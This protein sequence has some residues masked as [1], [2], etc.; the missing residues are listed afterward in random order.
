MKGV[1]TFIYF[2]IDKLSYFAKFQRKQPSSW[3]INGRQI[4]DCIS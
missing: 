2:Y 3:G 4:W 1:D